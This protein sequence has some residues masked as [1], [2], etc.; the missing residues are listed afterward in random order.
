MSSPT[1]WIVVPSLSD[2]ERNAAATPKDAIIAQV[3][4]NSP[5]YNTWLNTDNGGATYNGKTY[6]RRMGPFTSLKEAQDAYKTGAQPFSPVP[7]VTINPDGSLSGPLSGLAGIADSIAKLAGT[8]K[9]IF[10]ALSD[11]KMWASVGW[12][13]LGA[14]LIGFALFKLTHAADVIE[15]GVGNVAKGL[16]A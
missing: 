11:W 5:Q 4:D 10:D 1:W 2:Q 15:R 8:I 16:V 9:G 13:I 12:I 6:Y 7:G 14:L 3:Q